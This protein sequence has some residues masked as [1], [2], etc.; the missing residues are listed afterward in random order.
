MLVCPTSRQPLR[1]ATTAELAA[2]NAA[3]TA[4]SAR[5]RAG[6]VVEKPMEAGLVPTSGEAVYPILEG[7]PILLSS[8]AIP[9]AP[10]N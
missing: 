3:I 2:V 5:N 9:L 7:I 10:S 1:E 6:N 4:G 8:E